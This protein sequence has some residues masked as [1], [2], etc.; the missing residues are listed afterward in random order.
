MYLLLFSL[1]PHGRQDSSAERHQPC[2]QHCV[3]SRCFYDCSHKELEQEL[4][5]LR[6]SPCLFEIMKQKL[7]QTIPQNI[8]YYFL[9]MPNCERSADGRSFDYHRGKSKAGFHHAKHRVG[10]PLHNQKELVKGASIIQSTPKHPK[11][12]VPKVCTVSSLCWT[13]CDII[14]LMLIR[15]SVMLL[16]LS[17]RLSFVLFLT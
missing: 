10:L 11:P 7:Q 8:R 1:F 17:A 16:A 2:F 4:C 14:L 12:S 5:S 13:C 9:F 3:N 6:P 15:L